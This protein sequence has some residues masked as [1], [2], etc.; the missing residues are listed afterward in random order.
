MTIYVVL[1]PLDCK[2]VAVFDSYDKALEFLFS[3]FGCSAC[4]VVHILNF[5]L[6]DW[7]K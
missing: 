6:N 2:P 5:K 7:K 1:Q 3:S 4:P